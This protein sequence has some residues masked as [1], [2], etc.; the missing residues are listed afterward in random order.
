MFVETSALVE[1]LT[2]GPQTEALL[3]RIDHAST[4]F[5]VSPTVE[6]EATVVLASKL[7]CSVADARGRVAAFVDE[8]GA[9][10]LS[11]TPA[12]GELAI[13][14]FARYGKGRGHP[15]KLNFGD[16]FAYAA[17]K[18]EGLPLL[19]VGNDFAA[20]DIGES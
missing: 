9:R 12:V 3:T 10:R 18:S 13:E 2:G 16:C 6:F 8:L 1:I 11:I 4:D 7:D 19:F 15:A 14:A 20:T 17:A 5:H